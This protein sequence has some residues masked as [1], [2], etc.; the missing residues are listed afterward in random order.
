MIPF[1]YG[2]MEVRYAVPSNHFP[3]AKNT[4]FASFYKDQIMLRKRDRQTDRETETERQRESTFMIFKTLQ[5]GF[6]HRR[7]SRR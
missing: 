7:M 4:T 6:R 1:I 3:L 5:F 2:K